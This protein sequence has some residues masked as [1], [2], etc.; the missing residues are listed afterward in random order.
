ML[1]TVQ[2][3]KHKKEAEKV[4]TIRFVSFFVAN[5]GAFDD[6]NKMTSIT[7]CTYSFV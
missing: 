1:S 6:L 4:T 7:C 2:Q 5:V 3:C